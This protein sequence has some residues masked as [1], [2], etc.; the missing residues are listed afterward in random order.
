MIVIKKTQLQG[1]QNI[2]STKILFEAPLSQT[3]MKLKSEVAKKNADDKKN[4]TYKC[5]QTCFKSKGF[6]VSIL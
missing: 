3:S 1:C 4:T 6:Y 5:F 2:S